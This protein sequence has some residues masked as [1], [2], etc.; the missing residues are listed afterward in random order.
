MLVKQSKYDALEEKYN[1]L[2]NAVV[3]ALKLEAEE[4]GA[5]ISIEEITAAIGTLAEDD[6]AKTI[7][8]LQNEI[9]GLKSQ[10]TEKDNAISALQSEKKD[11]EDK[12][13]AANKSIEQ[14]DKELEELGKKPDTDGTEGGAEGQGDDFKSEQPK[15]YTDPEIEGIAETVKNLNKNK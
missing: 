3:S 2:Y 10:A 11:A 13:E 5:V 4:E 9:A 15:Y 1:S 12:L 14:K 7:E 6:S 8:S